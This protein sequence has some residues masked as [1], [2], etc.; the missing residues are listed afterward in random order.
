MNESSPSTAN[1]PDAGARGNFALG[2]RKQHRV[3]VIDDSPEICLIIEETL[4]LSGFH[5]LIAHDGST[6]IALAR[7][8]LPD[9]IICDVRMPGM[10]GCETL[11]VLRADAATSTIPFVFLSGAADHVSMRKGMELGADDYLP[12]PFSPKELLASVNARIQKQAEIKRL[13]DRQL[14]ELRGSLTMALPHELRTPL[15]GIMGLSHLMMEDYQEMT[16]EEVLETARF[17]N[18]SAL[19]LHRMIENFLVY[20][21]V[22]LMGSESRL[23]D[24]QVEPQP[25]NVQHVVP[26]LVRRVASRHKREGDLLLRVES[27]IVLVP[28]DNLVKIV[29]EL[30]D[31]AFKFSNPGHPVLVASEVVDGRFSLIVADK[32][33]GM[34]AEQIARIGPHVQF[35][36][37][38]F[39][40]QGSGLGLFLAK[41]ITELLGGRFH[42]ESK[43]GEG[44]TVRVSFAAPGI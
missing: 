43:V 21:Q 19:R 7:E 30:A 8:H 33:R 32:G 31:N 16:P 22:E 2:Q 28:S 20:S 5:A 41:R 9:L 18:E 10:D 40:Q 26:N 35:E 15:N 38:T 23:A 3:L 44:S 36:R 25:V 24:S 34:S 27:A 13:A 29:E 37:G 6:G 12:K 39:E 17:I 1:L 42:I 14:N 11:Q 4:N